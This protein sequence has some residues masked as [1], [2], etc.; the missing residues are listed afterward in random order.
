MPDARCTRGPVC[1]K[2]VKNAHEHTGSAE[3][4]DIPCAMV[5]R[6]MS[7]SPRRSGLFD[8]VVSRI[9]PTEP[10]WDDRPPGDLTPTIEASGPPDFAVR[11]NPS[12]PRGF[13]GQ[14]PSLPGGSPGK[15]PFV[16]AP[17]D[18]SRIL[19]NPPCHHVSRLTLPR[20]PHPAPRL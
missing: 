5:L 19:A 13:A 7:G 3:T 12:S 18:R 8:T 9:W 14:G 11:S 10:G 15:A 6:L 1:N 4:S 16:S 17:F 2:E 20:P